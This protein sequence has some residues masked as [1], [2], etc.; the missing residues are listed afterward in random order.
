MQAQIF[1]ILRC[2]N[3]TKNVSSTKKK[4]LDNLTA[5]PL[6]KL[7]TQLFIT[8]APG[9]SESAYKQFC[10]PLINQLTDSHH[11]AES[12]LRS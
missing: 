4:Y 5:G 2:T 9:L 1:S 3:A 7:H 8:Q 10:D 12:F 6:L 11:G